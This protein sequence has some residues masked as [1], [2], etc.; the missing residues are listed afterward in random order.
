E[1]ALEWIGVDGGPGL[2]DVT[3]QGPFGQAYTHGDEGSPTVAGMPAKAPMEFPHIEKPVLLPGGKYAQVV[4]EALAGVQ[5][6]LGG[7]VEVEARDLGIELQLANL[8]LR[9]EGWRV[10]LPAGRHSGGAARPDGA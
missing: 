10:A 8:W 1:L 3:R 2:V 5:P 7:E 4:I 9:G 6:R